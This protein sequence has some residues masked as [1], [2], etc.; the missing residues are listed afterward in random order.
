MI[1]PFFF[2]LVLRR[3]CQV[4]RSMFNLKT[5]NPFTVTFS[6]TWLHNE[7]QLLTNVKMLNVDRF[8]HGDFFFFFWFVKVTSLDIFV[9]FCFS[10]NIISTFHCSLVQPLPFVVF[11]RIMNI[12]SE[13]GLNNICSSQKI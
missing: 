2:F 1:F 11:I 3:Q 4:L 5:L 8:L 13:H 9:I 12:K 6:F 7:K 10:N